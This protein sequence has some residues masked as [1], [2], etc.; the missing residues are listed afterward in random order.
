MTMRPGLIV[1]WAWTGLVVAGAIAVG[2]SVGA[3]DGLSVDVLTL[4]LVGVVYAFLGLLVVVRSPGN[5]VAWLFFVVA[6][7][8]VQSGANVLVLGDGSVPPEHPSMW[9]V[10]AVVWD[11]S[12]YFVGLFV[13]VF[14]FF[15]IFPTGRFLTRRWA[16]AGWAGAVLICMA[17][18][19]AVLQTDIGPEEQGWTISNPIGLMETSSPILLGASA[20]G[21]LLLVVG[22]VLAIIT[23]YRRSEAAVH[24]QIK[25]VLFGLGVMLIGFFGNWL[26]PD[27][28]P[29]WHRDLLFMVVL[30]AIPVSVMVA[31]NRYRLYDI[32]RLVSRTVGYL[33]VVSLV[34]LVYVAGA[35]WLPSRLIGNQSPIFVAASTLA[36]AALFNPLRKRVLKL[37][38][39]RFNRSSYNAEQLVEHFGNLIGGQREI[40]GL[41]KDTT[42]LVTEAVQP[43]SIGVWVKWEDTNT[44]TSATR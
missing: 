9:D 5:S 33:I 30:T 38:D 26:L 39:R 14:L 17:P 40:T 42:S 18:L 29:D 44:G 15:Y 12:A 13:P 2:V 11:N 32:D 28:A 4:P 23:R 7:W 35:V 31:I 21:L 3:R 19:D 43:T 24:S 16:W 20:L 8:V 36:A 34:G 6:T 10:M 41:I 37:V 22:G 1:A 25:W 27:N